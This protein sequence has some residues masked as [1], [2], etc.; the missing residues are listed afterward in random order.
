MRRTDLSRK[1]G[2]VVATIEQGVLAG[3]SFNLNSITS[4]V[5][6]ELDLKAGRVIESANHKIVNFKDSEFEG[7]LKRT[8]IYT[9]DSEAKNLGVKEIKNICGMVQ[10]KY[11]T[12]RVE[13]S[14]IVEVEYTD[15]QGDKH[16]AFPV[17][18]KFDVLLPNNEEEITEEAKRDDTVTEIEQEEPQVMEEIEINDEFKEEVEATEDVQ[19]TYKDYIG[20]AI[21]SLFGKRFF[22]SIP[23]E[24]LKNII[25]D[26]VHNIYVVNYLEQLYTDDSIK[27]ESGEG[28]QVIK[29]ILDT[30]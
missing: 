16:K 28:M 19:K 5:K 24:C 14:L 29:R 17:L 3:E 10:V 8:D 9:Y 20:E 7:T 23:S 25:I 6:S 13:L 27:D 1:M 26:K 30:L 11:A 15:N 2:R 12:N 18:K 4:I 21:T 22:S